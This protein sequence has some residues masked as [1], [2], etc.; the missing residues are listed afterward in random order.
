MQAVKLILLMVVLAKAVVFAQNSVTPQ[1]ITGAQY[2][3]CTCPPQEDRDAARQILQCVVA[4]ILQQNTFIGTVNVARCG[5][6]QWYRVAYL[7]MSDPTQQC[8]SG[9]REYRE[10]GV[11]A[12]GRPGNVRAFGCSSL[13]FTTGSHLYSKVCGQVVGYQIGSTD[14]FAN[15]QYPIDTGYVDGISVT[16]GFPH[17]HIWTYAAGL[18]EQFVAGNAQ[19]TCPCVVAGRPI[20]TSTQTPPSFVENNYYCESG[21]PSSTYEHTNILMYLSIPVIHSGMASSVKVSAVAMES[22]HHGSM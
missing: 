19:Y 9:L 16:Y 11:R 2:G 14:V 8:P 6:G 7:N 15:R 17:M 21:N 20:G 13:N 10:N 22:L 4:S 5:P 1:V 12:C 3:T 18:S